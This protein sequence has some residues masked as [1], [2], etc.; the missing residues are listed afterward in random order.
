MDQYLAWYGK[1]AHHEFYT[2]PEVKQAYRDWAAHLVHRVNSVNGKAYRDDPAIFGWE[3]ANEPRCKG[4]GP[5]SPGWTNATKVTYA[6][7]E[8]PVGGRDV[9]LPQV[10]RPESSGVGRR[11]G[12]PQRRRRPLDLQGQRWRRQ[13]RAHRAPQHRLRHVPHV[14]RGLGCRREVGRPLDHR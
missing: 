1:T 6:R 7:D 3:L 14:P 12:L 13:R 4:T 10:D 9:V 8:A 5:G 11:R 2:A